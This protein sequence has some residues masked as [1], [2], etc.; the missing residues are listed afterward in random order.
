MLE[1]GQSLI[2]ASCLP[3]TAPSTRDR[4]V[5]LGVVSVGYLVPTNDFDGIVHSVFARAC[6]IACDGTLLTLAPPGVAEGPTA[7]VLDRAAPP[8]LRALFRIGERIC[9]RQDVVRSSRVTI[10]VGATTVWRPTRSRSQLPDSR[11]DR[12]LRIAGALLREH[13]RHVPHARDPA[14]PLWQT[15]MERACRALDAICAGTLAMRVIGLGEGLT[16]AGDDFLVGLCAGLDARKATDIRRKRFRT[17]L[18][19]VLTAHCGRTTPIA[20]HFLRMAARGH[21]SRHLV[22][23]LDALI[24]EAAQSRVRAALDDLL[25]VG[26]T[27]GVATC[28]GLRSGLSVWLGTNPRSQGAS[29]R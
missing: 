9:R 3:P 22:R 23:A 17:R 6:N 21:F 12:N 8:D 19:A 5:L 18:G 15:A 27:S 14:G 11:I 20:A 4:T 28:A 13:R 1:S 26:A 25:A 2:E 10:D 7:L 16:P 29:R 24:T